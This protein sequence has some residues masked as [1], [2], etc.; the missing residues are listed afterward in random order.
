MLQDEW[1]IGSNKLK[2]LFAWHW[3]LA[4]VEM[5][6]RYCCMYKWQV[7]SQDMSSVNKNALHLGIVGHYTLGIIIL[8]IILPGKFILLINYKL[9]KPP[10]LKGSYWRCYVS[11]YTPSTHFKTILRVCKIWRDTLI[12]L[13]EASQEMMIYHSDRDPWWWIVLP[14]KENHLSLIGS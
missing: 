1:I 9:V 2:L 4:F 6:C 14:K 5:A 3:W 7:S 11:P 12:P 13:R 8:N 10:L